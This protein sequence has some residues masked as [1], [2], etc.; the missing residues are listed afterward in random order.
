MST[1]RIL[2]TIG[3]LKTGKS[4]SAFNLGLRVQKANAC[5]VEDYAVRD[6]LIDVSIE[7]R[8]NPFCTLRLQIDVT[9]AHRTIL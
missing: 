2:T 9:L 8:R 5:A 3:L 1:C 4:R 7:V 6:D